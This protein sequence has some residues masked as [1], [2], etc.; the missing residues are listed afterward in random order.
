MDR[1]I[2]RLVPDGAWRINA[3]SDLQLPYSRLVAGVRRAIASQPRFEGCTI[4]AGSYSENSDND[5]VALVPR[6][7]VAREGQFDAL[8]DECRALMSGDSAWAAARIG[9]DDRGGDRQMVLVPEAAGPDE[10]ELV[11]AIAAA[12]QEVR[13]LRGSWLD[14]RLDDQGHPGVAPTIYVFT[15]TF[16]SARVNQQSAAMNSLIRRL[17]PSGRFRFDTARDVMLPLTAL[18]QE[19]NRITDLDPA[20]A[21]CIVSSASYRFNT[22]DDRWYLVPRGRL[23]KAE[24]NALVVDLCKRVMKSQPEWGKQGVGVFENA[25]GELDIDRP[26]PAVAAHYFSNAMHMFWQGDYRGADDTLALASLDAPDNVVYRYWRVIAELAEG[27]QKLAEERLR[28]TISGFDVQRH[29]LAHLE[30]M[31]SIY[32]IQGP[33]RLAL[34]RA[35]DKA[36]VARTT[37]AAEEW[38]HAAN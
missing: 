3:A 31:R 28:R 29:S 15:R 22:D 30:V 24:Q 1:I 32:R 7:Q 37:R 21:G 4:L 35:E 13:E 26:N 20:F 11:R 10:N 2:A 6:F 16:D 9:L 17:V 34:I 14:V 8:L 25:T 38:L 18:L 12:I 33:L 19:I 36:M 23:W 27:N 5:S